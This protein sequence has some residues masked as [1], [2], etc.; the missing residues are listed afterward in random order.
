MIDKFFWYIGIGILVIGY[1]T[2]AL[3]EPAPVGFLT[4]L[5]FYEQSES[6]K[7]CR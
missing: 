7:E 5:A 6:R 2:N 3:L 1:F 4:G